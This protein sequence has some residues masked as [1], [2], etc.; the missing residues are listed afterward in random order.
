MRSPFENVLARYPELLKVQDISVNDETDARKACAA[1]L[2]SYFEGGKNQLW[3]LGD[4]KCFMRE[5]VSKDLD[6]KEQ[7][8]HTER[9]D[10]E[11]RAAKR[12]KEQERL[13]KQMKAIV[14][15]QRVA[16]GFVAR[17]KVK[18][19][20]RAVT[21]LQATYRMKQKRDEFQV[22]RV[23]V[24]KI[25]ALARGFIERKEFGRVKKL[26]P[27]QAHVRGAL[28]RKKF[29]AIMKTRKKYRHLLNDVSGSRLH[30]HRWRLTATM[31]I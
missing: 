16:R 9:L 28:T 19:Y 22:K 21:V 5:Q 10:R 24:V 15:L 1:L 13:A 6:E 4:T 14:K 20:L 12:K 18:R 3:A 23:A 27:F 8:I 25:Q 30:V 29:N 2:Q 31:Y 11:E 7:K 26:V 17:Q